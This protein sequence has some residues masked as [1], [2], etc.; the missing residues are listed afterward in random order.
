[1]GA[2]L[3]GAADRGEV[4]TESAKAMLMDYLAPSLDTTINATSGAIWLF[5]RHFEQ[6]KSSKKIPV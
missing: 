2:A 6:C 1:M 3:F 5:A 4:S